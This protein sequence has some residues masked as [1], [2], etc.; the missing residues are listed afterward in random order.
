MK[1]LESNIMQLFGDLDRLLFVGTCRLNVLVMLIEW[2][3]KEKKS[4]M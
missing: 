2:I 1:I 3:V 4:G